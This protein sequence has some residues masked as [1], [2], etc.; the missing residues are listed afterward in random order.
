MPLTPREIINEIRHVDE[1]FLKNSL[2]DKYNSYSL[3]DHPDNKTEICI[4]SCKDISFTLSSMSYKELYEESF[5]R[6]LFNYLMLD[7]ALIQFNYL[8]DKGKIYKHRLAY[9]PSP[10]M[11]AF[12]HEPDLYIE[13]PMYAEIIEPSIVPVPIRFDFDETAFEELHHPK[14]HFT[15]GQYKNCR[16][17]TGS[18]IS[19]IIFVDFILRSFYNTAYKSYNQYIQY[20]RNIFDSTI[21]DR[22]KSF[23]HMNLIR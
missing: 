17:A 22:E 11:E 7:G 9:L 3:R 13:Q 18:P 19:P 12:Q 6:N 23:L 16:I 1:V 10:N 2:I 5:K 15:L 21:T 20:P 8:F 14:S 4:S